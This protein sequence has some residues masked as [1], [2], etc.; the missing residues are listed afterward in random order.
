MPGPG[1][2]EQQLVQNKPFQRKISSKQGPNGMTQGSPGKQQKVINPPSIPSHLS[3]FGYEENPN[4]QLVQQKSN[5][6]GYTGLKRD[7]VGPGDYNIHSATN[8][9]GKATSGVVSWKK[10]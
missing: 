4:G 1:Q 7:M 5:Q 8:L 9:V 6:I 2:Y 3:V 10:P